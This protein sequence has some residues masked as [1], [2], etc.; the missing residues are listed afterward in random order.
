M[1]IPANSVRPAPREMAPVTLGSELGGNSLVVVSS[2]RNGSSRSAPGATTGAGYR[3]VCDEVGAKRGSRV[4]VPLCCLRAPSFGAAFRVC[5]LGG[6]E[7][8]QEQQ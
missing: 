1:G 2:C 8:D 3:R 7:Q 5:S 4:L 6:E